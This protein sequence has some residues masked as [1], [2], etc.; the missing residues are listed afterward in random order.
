M[1]IQHQ[2]VNLPVFVS[3]GSFSALRSFQLRKHIM[4]PVA[5]IEHNLRF[6]KSSIENQKYTSATQRCLIAATQHG[7]K[8]LKAI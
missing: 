5:T 3:A 4:S 1:V 7:S 2:T 8:N 6:N